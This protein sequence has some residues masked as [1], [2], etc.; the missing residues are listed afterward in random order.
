MERQRTMPAQTSGAAD[1]FPVARFDQI[2]RI[3]T[4]HLTK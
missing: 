3:V 2:Q 4:P 1:N